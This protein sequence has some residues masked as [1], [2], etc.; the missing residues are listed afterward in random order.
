MV[1]V[2]SEQARVAYDSW[3]ERR[4]LSS[5][6]CTTF[7]EGMATRQAFELTQSILVRNLDD[8]ILVSDQELETAI[9]VLFEHTHN[10]AEG[11]GA[12]SLAALRLKLRQELAGKKVPWI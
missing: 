1:A 4:I 2:Q 5:D 9:R 3:R 7:A 10:I 12:A 6:V 11:A 8:F